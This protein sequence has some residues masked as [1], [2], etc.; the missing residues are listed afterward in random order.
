MGIKYFL[1]PSGF[2]LI[3]LM[4]VVVIVA[5]IASIAYPSYQ[6]QIR[7]TR[8]SDAKAAL[9]DAAAKME[10]HY[11]QFARYSAT[12]ANSGIAPT[13]P[14]NFYNITA[15]V[16]GAT[17]QTFT[18]TAA[19]TNQQ[20]GDDCGDLRIFQDQSKDVINASLTAAQCDWD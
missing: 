14:E 15:T 13:S 20:T 17:S 19:R 6:D 2:S 4:V 7:K 8:R 11:T 18:L 3:E 10:R 12:L 16:T 5:I 1:K 9:M